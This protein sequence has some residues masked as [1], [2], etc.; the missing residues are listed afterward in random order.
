MDIGFCDFVT[1]SLEKTVG[2]GGINTLIS[3]EYNEI[4]IIYHTYNDCDSL[5]SKHLHCVLNHL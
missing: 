1:V 4:L 3:L 5:R 2:K